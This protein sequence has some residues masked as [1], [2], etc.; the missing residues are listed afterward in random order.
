MWE[1]DMKY[2][3]CL[4]ST[5][6]LWV[7]TCNTLSFLMLK[8]EEYSR[9]SNRTDFYKLRDKIILLPGESIWGKLPNI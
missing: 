8:F 2:P 1:N 9:M 3:K 7:F 5:R 6:I 4:E